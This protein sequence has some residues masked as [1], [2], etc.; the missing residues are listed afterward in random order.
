MKKQRIS[1]IVNNIST[2]PFQTFSRKK[3][4]GSTFLSF[5]ISFDLVD[6]DGKTHHVWFN[7]SFRFPPPL[8]DGDHVEVIGKYGRILGFIGR[9][10]FYAVRIIDAER[11]MEYTAWRNKELASATEKVYEQST[12]HSGNDA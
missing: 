3:E 9:K 11:K 1:G 7:R 8:E 5:D 4:S 12:P 10:N 2:N 6:G